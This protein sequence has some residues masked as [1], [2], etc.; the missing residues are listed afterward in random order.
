MKK[1]DKKILSTVLIGLLAAGGQL[2][3]E[4][5]SALEPGH[6]KCKGI[7]TKWTNDCGANG[8]G[9]HYHAKTDFNKNEWIG[10]SKADCDKI[11]RAIKN[12]AIKAY[13]KKI[14]KNTASAVK[15]GKK[16]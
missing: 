15:S 7:A 2:I 8:H 16:I 10:M 13:I 12:P 3:G 5:A 4:E 14:Q 11:Q 6:I 1:Q 9:C